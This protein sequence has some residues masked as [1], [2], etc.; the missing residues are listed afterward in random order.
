MGTRIS[1][2]RQRT[3]E[4]PA[5]LGHSTRHLAKE[6]MQELGPALVPNEAC[7]NVPRGVKGEGGQALKKGGPLVAHT[8]VELPRQRDE[9]VPE[10]VVSRGSVGPS[11]PII[12]GGGV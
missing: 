12:L 9:G 10:R 3:D 6:L 1:S 4:R 8:T 5:S 2:V 7:A 11:F